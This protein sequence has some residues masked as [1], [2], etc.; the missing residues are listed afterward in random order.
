MRHKLR[1][2]LILVIFFIGLLVLNYPVLSTLHN[3]LSQGRVM[4]VYDDELEKMTEEEIQRA[5]QEAEVYNE[6]IAQSGPVLQDAF[7]TDSQEDP[8]YLGIL[9]L[10]EDGVMGSLEIPKIH[11]YLPIYHGTSAES[12]RRGVGHLEGSSFPI[13]GESTHSILTGHRGLPQAELFTDLDQLEEGDVFYIHILEETLAY[14]IYEIETVE[15]ENVESLT[16]QEGR[17]LVTL[18]TCTPYGIN[19]H[20]MLVHAQRIPYEEAEEYDSAQAVQENL[21]GWL[22][23]QKTLW[24]SAGIVLLLI[25]YGVIQCIRIHRRKN[26]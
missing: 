3:Q 8:T 22:L 2:F 15:P 9:N 16:I 26:V 18:V 13:G 20:R 1:V 17:D 11:V 6:Q 5:R 25:L 21:L 24:L 10:N 12:L 4:A 23:K 7:S 14:E 19:S